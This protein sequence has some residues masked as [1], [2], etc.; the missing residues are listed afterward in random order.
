MFSVVQFDRK[1]KTLT[2]K[3]DGFEKR[4]DAHDWIE[5]NEPENVE[6]PFWVSTKIDIDRMININVEKK[7]DQ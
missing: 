7:E 5:E 3:E 4:K 1:E 2:V 6:M